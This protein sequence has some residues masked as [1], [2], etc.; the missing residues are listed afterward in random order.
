LKLKIKALFSVM[1]TVRNNV[2][3]MALEMSGYMEIAGPTTC[4]TT[5]PVLGGGFALSLRVRIWSTGR[6]MV[7]FWTLANPAKMTPGPPV[8]G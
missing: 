3:F 4:I 8:T 7:L 5:L 6:S 2:I 1:A